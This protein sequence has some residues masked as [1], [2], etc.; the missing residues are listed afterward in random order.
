MSTELYQQHI[1]KW[2]PCTRCPIGTWA[3]RKVLGS[4]TL[5]AP[6]LFIGEGPGVAEDTLGLPFVGA[7]GKLFRSALALSGFGPAEFFLTNLVACRPTDK[8]GGTNRPPSFV[9]MSNCEARLYEVVQI[10]RPKHLVA[11]GSVPHLRMLETLGR[12][13]YLR[14]KF[15]KVRHPSY[16]LRRGGET[17]E[18][19]SPFIDSLREIKRKGSSPTI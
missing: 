13:A 5:K 8:K 7:S 17:G 16:I 6:F 9:E 15:W 18:E 4:G 10:V 11:V 3:F 12:Y 1:A 2:V 14:A 19:W